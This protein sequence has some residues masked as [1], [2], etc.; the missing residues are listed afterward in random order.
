MHPSQ[1][2]RPEGQ[3]LLY[4]VTGSSRLGIANPRLGGTSRNF[5]STKTLPRL[6]A[7]VCKQTAGQPLEVSLPD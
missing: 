1:D 4:C 5:G 3:A 6:R 2:C 7:G